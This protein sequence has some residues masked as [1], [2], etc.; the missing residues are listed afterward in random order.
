MDSAGLRATGEQ[1]NAQAGRALDAQSVAN[2]GITCVSTGYTTVWDHCS[3]LA[4]SKETR[5]DPAEI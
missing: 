4:N 1:S 2:G 5:R 3:D